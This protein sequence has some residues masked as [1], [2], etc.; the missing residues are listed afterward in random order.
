MIILKNFE[1]MLLLHK[2]AK[3]KA[4]KEEAE[5]NFIDIS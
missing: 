4:M 1:L 5:L 2:L 3:E